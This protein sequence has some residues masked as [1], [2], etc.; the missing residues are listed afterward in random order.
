MRR[1]KTREQKTEDARKAF[2]K[3]VEN[4]LGHAAIAPTT[5]HL[6]RKM[7]SNKA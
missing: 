6:N 1:Q 5:M 4:E 2:V 3:N 7:S